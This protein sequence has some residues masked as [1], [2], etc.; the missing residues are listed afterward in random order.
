MRKDK[1]DL[2]YAGMV[3]E[4]YFG[5]RPVELVTYINDA[6]IDLDKKEMFLMTAKTMRVR[7]L[8]WHDAV[9][10]YLETW[11]DGKSDRTYTEWLRKSFNAQYGVYTTPSGVVVTPKVGRKTVET[12][13]RIA[14]VDD[15]YIRAILG[16]THATISD[17][18]TD[19]L[20]LAP[21]LKEV[22]ETKHYMITEKVL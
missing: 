6:K 7:Y 20:M 3:L 19:Y 9:T 16:H 18:Y 17:V 4:F 22:L 1:H 21:K 13:L 15:L 12:Q 10:P 2:I 11:L 8:T 5:A 14:N